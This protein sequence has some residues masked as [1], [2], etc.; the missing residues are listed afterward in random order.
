M[1]DYT[2]ILSLAGPYYKKGRPMDV[3]HIDWMM[4]AASLVCKMESIDDSLLMPLVILHDVGYSAV[5]NSRC[6][7][8]DVR[9]AHMAEGAKI[10][11]AI[12]QQLKYPEDKTKRIVHYV[13]VHDNWALGD[14]DCF[15]NDK[16][17]GTFNDLDY[18]WITTP[19]GFAAVKQMLSK[20]PHQ[21]LEFILSND[22]PKLRPFCT[23]TTKNLYE[24]YLEDR[25]EELAAEA[26]SDDEKAD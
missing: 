16:L 24:Q 2:K 21:M 15:N 23:R 5:Q 3:E 11:E 25:Q 18:T 6:F 13:S 8:I 19:R 20:S 9:K 4:S 26:E 10:A 7:D 1:D 14:N 17:L 12:L 22:K